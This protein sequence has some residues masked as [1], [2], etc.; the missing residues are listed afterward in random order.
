MSLELDLNDDLK[1][2]NPR[3]APVKL[4]E[5]QKCKAVVNATF[6]HLHDTFE[7]QIET[8]SGTYVH[9]WNN[10]EM[11]MMCEP[12]P[13][14]VW[15]THTEITADDGYNDVLS[16]SAAS[17]FIHTED[18]ENVIA[19]YSYEFLSVQ[20]CEHIYDSCFH[21][22]EEHIAN[23]PQQFH[24]PNFHDIFEASIHNM[25]HE[26]IKNVQEH[27]EQESY[28]RL[29]LTSPLFAYWSSSSDSSGSGSASAASLEKEVDFI[30]RVAMKQ[31]FHHHHVPIRSYPDTRILFDGPNNP[32]F[33]VWKAR[34]EV[35]RKKPQAE[36][37]TPEWFEE[38]NNMLTMSNFYKIW[39]SEKVANSLIYEKCEAIDNS[40]EVVARR[41]SKS[42]MFVNTES[43]LHKGQKYEPVSTMFYEHKYHTHVEEFGCLK[44][45]SYSFLGASPDGINTDP[46]SPRYGRL[47]EIKNIVNREINGIPKKEYW[48]QMQGQME[49]CD[50]D[51]CD[52][53]ETR[54]VEYEGYADFRQDW[55]EQHW[56]PEHDTIAENR[57]D[58]Y[59]GLMIHFVKKCA[60][61]GNLNS[62]PVY[63]YCPLHFSLKEMEQWERNMREQRE[64]N[65]YEWV[66]NIYWKLEEYSCVLVCRNRL[67]FKHCIAD[68]ERFWKTIERERVTGYAHRAPTRR[69]KKDENGDG[70]GRGAVVKR[71]AKDA[72]PEKVCLIKVTKLDA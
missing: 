70:L 71:K 36:Q 51:E 72:L 44:H 31:F 59:R 37:R 30:I 62:V 39:E 2:T 66:R 9:V 28:S 69:V 13:H 63:E 23:Y 54:F 22:M 19:M 8:E 64:R 57:D 48:V 38:R 7:T 46:A 65:G 68:V 10:T 12:E 35:L 40:P 3:L 27:N 18:V 53:L 33:S 11:D 24:Q 67:W 26:M 43:P 55:D 50:L 61:T 14:S 60:I 25:V 58:K 16:V 52:F 1:I 32:K 21:F 29:A 20:D 34:I 5:R 15:D 49:V 42:G 45:D 56:D 4:N 41:E 17:T 47:L 6:D